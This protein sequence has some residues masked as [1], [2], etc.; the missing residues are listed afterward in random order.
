MR[1]RPDKLKNVYVLARSEERETGM[2]TGRM[3]RRL[4]EQLARLGE[5]NA[6]RH[7]YG[8]RAVDNVSSAHWK[9]YQ[10]FIS[11]LDRAVRSQQQIVRDCEMQLEAQ[12]K[13]W[14]VKRQRLQSL[15]RVL[16]KSR[17]REAAR[18]DRQE[19][20]QIDDMAGP[21]DQVIGLDQVIEDE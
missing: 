13:R 9:D 6:F 20:R 7:D 17:A 21:L 11:R 15:E 1:R 18:R 4:N 16:E 3:Q 2:A 14:M 10:S 8:Q 5:L 12:R 19:Q